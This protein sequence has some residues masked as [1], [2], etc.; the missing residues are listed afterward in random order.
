MC[1][2]SSSCVKENLLMDGAKE[3]T[4]LTVIKSAF[5]LRYTFMMGKKKEQY[6]YVSILSIYTQP[7]LL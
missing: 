5:A 4:L 3:E 7:I 1:I 6:V 2:S